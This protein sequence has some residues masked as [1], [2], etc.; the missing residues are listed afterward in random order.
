M[1]EQPRVITIRRLAGQRTWTLTVQGCCQQF[2]GRTYYEA[3]GKAVLFFDGL[4]EAR[5]RVF[6]EDGMR[7][8][9]CP[10]AKVDPL[11]FVKPARPAEEA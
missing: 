2:T 10:V 6:G 1:A 8:V 11:K 7:F 9:P 3:L 5:V 4:M